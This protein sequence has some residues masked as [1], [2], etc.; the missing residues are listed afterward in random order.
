MKS[1]F[2]ILAIIHAKFK[3]PRINED[4]FNSKSVAEEIIPFL[5]LGKPTQLRTIL[6]IK[7]CSI[8]ESTLFG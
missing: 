3:A 7:N 6:P 5:F 1:N 2:L 8:L 4:V